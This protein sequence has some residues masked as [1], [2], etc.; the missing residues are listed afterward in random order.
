M[1]KIEWRWPW[2]KSKVRPPKVGGTPS[3]DQVETIDFS[4]PHDFYFLF[5]R[6]AGAVTVFEPVAHRIHD[7]HDRRPPTPRWEESS[8]NRWIVLKR[9]SGSRVY[10]PRDSL[11]YIEDSK[12]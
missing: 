3:P 9:P 2:Q 1:P 10:V 11:L 12:P 5:G 8:H 4:K 6:D 7:T